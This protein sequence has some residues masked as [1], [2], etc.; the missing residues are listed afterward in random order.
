MTFYI[1]ADRKLEPL[2]CI[3]V[4]EMGPNEKQPREFEKQ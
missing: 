4:K 3:T 2:F 1:N